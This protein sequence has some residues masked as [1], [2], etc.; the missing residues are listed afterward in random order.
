MAENYAIE[1]VK[2]NVCRFTA[3]KYHAAFMVTDTGIFVTDPING[4]AARWLKKI[5]ATL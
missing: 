1:Q 2:D 3:S 4:E 5:T